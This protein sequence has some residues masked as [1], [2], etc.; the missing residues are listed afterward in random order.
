M[1]LL[2]HTSFLCDSS[3]V[4]DRKLLVYSE[5]GTTFMEAS[6]A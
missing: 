3:T 2:G 6:M 5:T 4:A 1:L